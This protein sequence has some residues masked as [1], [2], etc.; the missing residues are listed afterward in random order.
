MVSRLNP[1]KQKL[2]LIILVI[3]LVTNLVILLMIILELSAVRILVIIRVII[4]EIIL[5]SQTVLALRVLTSSL[6]TRVGD[7]MDCWVPP[8]RAALGPYATLRDPML[9]ALV[10]EPMYCTTSEG[11]IGTQCGPSYV[12]LWDLGLL[13]HVLHHLLYLSLHHSL[14]HALCNL[15]HQVLHHLLHHLLHHST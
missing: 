10:S 11:R 9:I 3:I 2:V 6:K 8:L 12:T 4:L 7:N 15:L 13:H 14:L 1:I 5:A